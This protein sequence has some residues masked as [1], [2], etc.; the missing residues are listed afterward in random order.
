MRTLVASIAASALVHVLLAIFA[1]HAPPAA[2]AQKQTVPLIVRDHEKKPPAPP[3]PP[4]K[5]IARLSP[6]RVPTTTAVEAPPRPT[7]PPPLP[8][9][10][11]VDTKATVKESSVA[12]AAKDGG[13]NM[14]ADPSDGK[15]AGDKQPVAP[16]PP[17]PFVAA[18]WAT[19]AAER[20]PPYPGAALR[21]EIE[22]QVMLKV[23][24]SPAGDVASVQVVK[25]LGFGCDEAAATWAKQH[26]HFRPA[27]RGGRPVTTC[28]LQ[29]MRFVLQR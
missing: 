12:V 19:D 5:R 15:P 17:E 3:P 22:G 28:L 21:A 9:G 24:V 11:S 23:C 7:T 4:P 26:W 27:R 20:S 2:A 25:G 18:E 16:P 1:R 14:F 6:K 8:Q 10:F 13:G 29:P